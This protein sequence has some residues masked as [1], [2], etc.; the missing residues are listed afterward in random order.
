MK[1]ELKNRREMHWPATI[2]DVA[3]QLGV[4]TSLVRQYCL[5]GIVRPAQD[6]RRRR[7]FMPE[8]LVQIE[9]Y[10]RVHGRK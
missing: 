10:R 2:G 5:I 1:L 7:L 8:D 4:S 9:E 3:Q 6:S